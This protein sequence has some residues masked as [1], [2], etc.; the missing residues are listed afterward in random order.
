M[1]MLRHKMDHKVQNGEIIHAKVDM[2]K[3]VFEVG[4]EE[5]DCNGKMK[6]TPWI[7]ILLIDYFIDCQYDWHLMLKL[8]ECYTR[9]AQE[10][11]L[12]VL[13]M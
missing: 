9:K 3:H 8:K 5:P 7:T 1:P 13:L 2:Q 6:V 4:F 12:Q 11:A 10:S